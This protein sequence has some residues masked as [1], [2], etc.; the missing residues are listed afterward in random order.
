MKDNSDVDL[1]EIFKIIFKQ[2]TIVLIFA[3]IGFFS[4]T[5]YSLSIKRIWQ[6]EFQILLS[7]KQQ[8]SSSVLKNLSQIN[9]LPSGGGNLFGSK[10]SGLKTELVILKSPSVLLNVYNFVKETKESKKS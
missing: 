4:S 2:K 10:N 6:G 9:N 8:N 7:K 1:K 3:A 5:L